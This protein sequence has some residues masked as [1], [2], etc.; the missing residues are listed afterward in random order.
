VRVPGIHKARLA[1]GTW[2]RTMVAS[3]FSAGLRVAK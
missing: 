2:M 3:P 1:I